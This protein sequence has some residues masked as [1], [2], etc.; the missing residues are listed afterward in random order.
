ML[1][2][3]KLDT[4]SF[5]IKEWAKIARSNGVTVELL[6]MVLYVGLCVFGVVGADMKVN[7]RSSPLHLARYTE[8]AIMLYEIDKA[9]LVPIST[10]ALCGVGGKGRSNRGWAKRGKREIHRKEGG[11]KEGE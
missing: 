7:V 6:A 8:C 10:N 4:D 11:E 3:R 9:L 1:E 2:D 5:T